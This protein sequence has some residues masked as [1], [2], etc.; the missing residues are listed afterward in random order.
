[1]TEAAS[2]ADTVRD[3]VFVRVKARLRPLPAGLAAV[4]TL[5]E[6][7]PRSRVHCELLPHDGVSVVDPEAGL[8]RS[9][10][11][12]ASFDLRI[13]D[14]TRHALTAG[15]YYIE[16][17][18][19][20]H[21]GDRIGDLSGYDA[22]GAETFSW[23]LTTNLRGT[24]REVVRVPHGTKSLVWTVMHRQGYFAQQPVL[25]HRITWL[26]SAARRGHRVWLVLRDAHM[27]ALPPIDLPSFGARTPLQRAYLRTARLRAAFLQGPSYDHF[28]AQSSGK[29]AL[30]SSSYATRFLL[31]VDS[32]PGIALDGLLD[33]LARQHHPVWTAIVLIDP[34]AQTHSVRTDGETRIHFVEAKAPHSLSR[35]A[36][37]YVARL[38]SG[39]VLDPDALA[40]VAANIA[41]LGP[42]EV[43]YA[44]SDSIDA[45]GR[46]HS[47]RFKPDWNP[48][49][50]LST[51]YIGSPAFFR[52]NGLDGW[53]VDA[54]AEVVTAQSW[55]LAIWASAEARG[56]QPT[57]AI[58][59][60]PKVLLSRRTES[61]RTPGVGS[62]GFERLRRSILPHLPTGA[63]LDPG[64]AA[65]SVHVRY[66][67]PA[68]LPLVSLI[69]PTRDRLDVLRRCVESLRERTDYPT[70]EVIVIDNDSKDVATL[71][72]FEGLAADPRFRVL[73]YP[74]AF[75]YSAI[76]NFGVHAAYGSVLGLLNNDV[77]VLNGEWL[78]EMVSHALRP[79]VGAVGAKLLYP[80]GG[81]QHA[82]VVMGIGGIAGHVYRYIEDGDDGNQGR[83]RVVQNYSAVTGA[84]LVVQRAHFYRVGGLDASNLH[85]AFNDVDFCLRLLEAGLRNVYTPHARL[86][87]HESL[88]RGRDDTPHKLAVQA[89]EQAFMRS[90]WRDKLSGDPAYNPNLTLRREDF[91]LA[92]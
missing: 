4:E 44:D 31:I 41:A 35:L 33:S 46:R 81:V 53:P 18:M 92:P 64:P 1:M 83:A 37:D 75:N 30:K 68:T 29:S 69:I 16:S 32:E 82:G 19:T 28:L 10:T 65:G 90:R 61:T 14:G 23:P 78:R 22:A 43:I 58:R 49:L 62:Q 66:P 55:V 91:S 70:W 26:E 74:G 57:R 20:R 34:G 54:E 12:S 71:R 45:D 47:P 38:S 50:L 8:Y 63:E 40:A 17:A 72:Y 79:G 27:P 11:D 60:I 85:V 77:E 86:V 3:E 39:D 25:L 88:S 24:V 87:H 42:A 13:A 51:D 36:G 2:R 5:L 52:C 67:L 9:A 73:K 59:H 15:W 89:R 56:E 48:D 6:H 21:S 76:N 84:C 7:L 80:H